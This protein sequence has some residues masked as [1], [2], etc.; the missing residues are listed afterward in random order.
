VR[1]TSSDTD[2]VAQPSQM[3][4]TLRR[5]VQEVNAAP[6]LAQAL[7]IIV[8]RVKQAISADVCSVY[9]VDDEGREQVLMATDGLWR[10]VVGRV[11]LAIDEGVVGLVHERAEPINLDDASTHA[12][13]R[14]VEETGEKGY[15]GFLGVPIIQHRT[16][17]GVL[18]VRRKLPRRFDDDEVAFMVTL[19][20]QLAGAI[21]HAKVSGGISGSQGAPSSASRF[22][23]G[24]PG[25]PGVVIGRAVVVYPPADLD[26]IPDRT[27]EDPTAEEAE[28]RTAVKEVQAELRAFQS[29]MG[30]ILPAEDRALFDAYVMM[31]GSDTLVDKAVARIRAGQ[32]AAGALRESI[33]EHTRIFDTMEDEYLRERASDIRDLGRRIL[34]R[35]QTS[36][37]RPKEYPQHTILLGEHLSAGQVAEVP[38]E[39]LRGVVSTHGSGSS[40]AAILA[41]ALGVPAVMGI[42]DVPVARVGEKEVIVDGYRGRVYVSPS[43]LVRE[44]YQ[45][46]AREDVELSASLQYLEN[47]PAETPDGL[48]VSLQLSLGLLADIDTPAQSAADG[49]GL[50]RTEIPFLIR[51]RFPS[52]EEQR[53]IYRQVIEVFAPRPVTMRTLDVGG[54]KALSY[55]PI[56]EDN[57][58]L[59]RRG[60][61][62]TLDHPEIFL[63]Q[64]RAML[65][66]ATGLDNLRMLL[67]MVSGVEE[68]DEARRLIERAHR[69][70]VEEGV[71]V[72]MPPVGVMVEIPSAVYQVDALASRVDFFSI[73]SNDLT[74]Y[75]LAV[76]RNN[77]YVAE[78]YDSLHPAVL[79][80]IVRVVE[81]ARRHGRLVSVCG[82]MAADPAGVLSLLGMDVDN[83][84]MNAGSL[85]QV[86][87][88]IRSFTVGQARALVNEALT[89]ESPC[90]IRRLFNNA[91]EEAGLGGLVRA[92]K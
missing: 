51:D 90:L 22:F 41:R 39:R 74:Q 42:G 88:V 52:E 89:L 54:D 70:L 48:H 30:A 82:E 55:F 3:L 72:S 66:A 4:D 58:F 92:G 28:F 43:K 8:S 38:A 20:A 37:R 40:H 7:P 15:H 85:S 12:R 78:L 34:V 56:K 91:L 44:E 49:V 71:P 62:I 9:L 53:R 60:I 87:W 83:L 81:G 63:T 29:R 23:D 59:G 84:S 17:L 31:L 69:D 76:D 68:L 25:A 46:L 13:Y 14:F 57:P 35:L 5:I 65:R 1:R 79:R 64:L 77:A 80:A 6:D 61:R 36:H 18:V 26:A 86:K 24:R 16:V 32:W 45:R 47:L 19:A 10:R 2:K 73:G 11:R 33:H 50:Y 67:P 75:L 21:T 27:A